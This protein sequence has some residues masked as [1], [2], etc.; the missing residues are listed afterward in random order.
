MMRI[1]VFGAGSRMMGDER[2]GIAVLEKLSHADLPDCVA[3]RE[4]GTDG[5]GLL[6]DIEDADVAIVVDCAKM[7]L[8]PGSV[9]VF[10]PEEVED[11]LP[12]HTVSLHSISLLRV[13]QLAQQLGYTTRIRIVGIEPARVEPS[14]E[15]TEPV[16]RAIPRAVEC[17]LDEIRRAL[18]NPRDNDRGD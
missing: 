7:G 11:R 17:V 6:T 3:L 15:L 2:A 10:G 5:Y 18:E 1:V 12:D 4:T 16:T 8:E 14:D 13:I 9:V